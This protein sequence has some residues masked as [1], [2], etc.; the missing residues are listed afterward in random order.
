MKLKSNKICEF[1]K[2]HNILFEKFSRV[3]LFGSILDSK[4]VP[5]DIDILLIY[6]NYYNEMIN[7]LIFIR[8]ILEKKCELPVDFTVLSEDEEKETDFLSR[9]SSSC[10]KLK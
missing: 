9:I 1:I 3:Y 8:T 2:H 7:D 5:N 6:S 4:K 10:V